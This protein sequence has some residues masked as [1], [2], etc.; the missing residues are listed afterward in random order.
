MPPI[1]TLFPYTTLF[2]SPLFRPNRWLV[3]RPVV[4]RGTSVKSTYSSYITSLVLSYRPAL[5][6]F[7]AKGSS[8]PLWLLAMIGPRCRPA[9]FRGRWLRLSTSLRMRGGIGSRKNFSGP[10]P[11]D[12]RKDCNE[13]RCVPEV[14]DEY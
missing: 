8:L 12:C 1:F 3:R 10:I 11:R 4:H 14:S 7:R 5:L 9:L 6:A 2:R 13:G